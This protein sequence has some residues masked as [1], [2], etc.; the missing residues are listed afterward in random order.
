MWQRLR[1]TEC[2]TARNKSAQK[3]NEAQA[4]AVSKRSKAAAHY[5][6]SVALAQVVA[7]N[8]LAG[9]K[10]WTM[11]WASDSSLQPSAMRG[12]GK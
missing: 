1:Q 4:R 7:A 5:T 12:M 10:E 3:K 9:R 6:R 2:K 8:R 11:V